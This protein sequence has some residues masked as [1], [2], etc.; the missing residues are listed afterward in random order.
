MKGLMLSCLNRKQEAYELVKAGVTANLRSHVC[1]HV[2]GLLYRSDQE[3][4]EAIK[5]YKNALRMDKENLQVLRD[6]AQLQIQM[7]DLPGFLETRQTLLELKPTQGP[8]W[9]SLALAHHLNGNFEVASTVLDAYEGVSGAGADPY[10]HSEI[11]LYKVSILEEGGNLSEALKALDAVESK[12]LLRDKVGS[13]ETRARVLM[14]MDRKQEAATIYRTLLRFNSE[15]Y[16][17]HRGLLA[18]MGY[19]EP[20]AQNEEDASKQ[21]MSTSTTT[22]VAWSSSVSDEQ[23]RQKGDTAS[24][25][26]FTEFIATSPEVGSALRDVYGELQK[27]FPHSTA[28]KRIPLDFLEGEDFLVAVDTFIRPFLARGVPSLFAT[29]KPL[30]VRPEKATMMGK[31]FCSFEDSL[32]E[33]G[34]FPSPLAECN[35]K[36]VQV[37]ASPEVGE[38]G[39]SSKVDGQDDA[40][41]SSDDVDRRSRSGPNALVWTRLCLSQHY[42]RLGHPEK[43]LKYADLCLS[44]EPALIEALSMRSKALKHCG[45][46]MAAAAEAQKARRLDGSDRYLNCMAVKALFRA[47]ET[48]EAERVANLFTRDSSSGF[49]NL[50]V[51]MQA[52]WF[53][54]VSGRAYATAGNFGMALKRFLQVDSHFKEFVEDQF[55]FHQYCVRKQTMRSYVDMLRMED[56]LYQHP[57]FEKAVIGAADVYLKLADSPQMTEEEK[58]AKAMAG[59]T[60]EEAKKYLAKRRKIAARRQKEREE[61]AMAEA[62]AAKGKN[63]KKVDSD[64]NG[65]ALTKTTDP[66]GEAL[67]LVKKLVIAAP[68]RLSGLLVMAEIQR[69]RGKLLLALSAVEQAMRVTDK[70]DPDVHPAIVRLLMSVESLKRTEEQADGAEKAE[71]E[72]QVVPSGLVLHVLEKHVASVLGGMSN[73]KEYHNSWAERNGEK[74][75]LHR[76]AVAKMAAE[77]GKDSSGEVEK[78]V[79]DAADSLLSSAIEEPRDQKRHRECIMI[80]DWLTAAALHDHVEKWQSKCAKAFPLSRRFGGTSVVPLYA[81]ALKGDQSRGDKSNDFKESHSENV[82]KLV[83]TTEK[84]EV[85]EG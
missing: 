32:K 57:A 83:D 78:S 2:Y 10:E 66:L 63:A 3:Y 29:L 46:L 19:K 16:E 44:D 1:W 42:D 61:A 69:R 13:M 40:S 4:E 43:A 5:C 34:K 64:P 74:S 53:E 33:T 84:L 48:E 80:E 68:D 67:K 73:A 52:T 21:A 81:D 75:L 79:R 39:S 9:V 24:W 59:M 26:S 49:G 35:G 70:D 17:Y 76:L 36:D 12:G 47:G 56:R 37:Q 30:Y 11:L 54:I 25:M 65:E 71:N 82:D 8:H 27:E 62:Q 41:S 60:P 31:L 6:L 38:N 14:K 50:L 23:T 20:R 22:A 7:R 77:L 45:D 58:E 18:A 72:S 55:D 15:N 85:R 28:A 51:D